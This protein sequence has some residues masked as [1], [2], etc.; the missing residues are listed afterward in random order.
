MKQPSRNGSV[1]AVCAAVALVVLVT[2][3]IFTAPHYVIECR[4]TLMAGC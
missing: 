1:T 2:W 3:A 4:N